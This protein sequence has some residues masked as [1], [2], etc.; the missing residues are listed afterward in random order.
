MPRPRQQAQFDPY[1]IFHALDRERVAYVLIGGLARVL[2]GSDEITRGVD[3]TPSM[4]PENLRRLESALEGLAARP[5]NGGALS[6]EALDQKPV[7]ELESDHGE[8]KLV[9]EPEGTRGY[10]DL[11]RAARREPIGQGLR[12]PVASPGDLVRM[13]SALGREPDELKI[14][15]MRRVVELDRGLSIER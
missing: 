2:E 14:E 1:E 8:I 9:R 7:L 11:R 3:L 10:D 6:I 15:T 12:I 5:R 4:R 13:L